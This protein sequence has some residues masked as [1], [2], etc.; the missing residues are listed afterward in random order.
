MFIYEN[1]LDGGLYVSDEKLD[2]DQL[3]CEQCGD[4]DQF[5]GRADTKEEAKKLLETEFWDKEYVEEFLKNW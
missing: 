3:Y 1:H 5:V 4:S 2:Y